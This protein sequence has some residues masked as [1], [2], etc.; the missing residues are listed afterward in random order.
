MLHIYYGLGK[1]KSS[2]LN[3]AALR[4]KGAGLKIGFFK[5]LKG[6]IS[7]EDSYLQKIADEFQKF[8]S[9]PK[10][11]IMMNEAEKKQAQQ[12]ALVGLTYLK[13]QAQ[14]YDVYFFDE[15]IDLTA[16]NVNFLSPIE[17]AEFL[18]CFKDKE[19]LISGHDL[20]ANLAKQADLITY[21][22]PE[23][24]YFEK[25]IKARLGIEF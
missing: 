9:I 13:K 4:A 18:A 22:K 19:V 15:I 12:E 17:L 3:G 10:F 14:K 21:F 1:G 20:P 24:H 25:G 23:K 8:Q 11:V 5:F 7:S 16:K 2:S 6:R